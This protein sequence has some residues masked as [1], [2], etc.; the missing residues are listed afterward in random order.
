MRVAR[1]A[2]ALA[3]LTMAVAA[4]A[5]AA[6]GA[7]P[8]EIAPM[9]GGVPALSLAP[10]PTVVALVI[11]TSH[12]V[13]ALQRMV[14]RAQI[15]LREGD[16]LSRDAVRDAV[17]RLYATGAFSGVAVETAPRPGGVALIFVLPP[18]KRITSFT[19]Q[20]ASGV[21]RDVLTQAALAALDDRSRPGAAAHLPTPFF[22]SQL[23]RLRQ[24]L[25]AEY[26]TRGYPNAQVSA[27]AEDQNESEVAVVF[28]IDEGAP[29][30]LAGISASGDPRLSPSALRAALGLKLGEILDSSEV[31]AAV[32]RLRITYQRSHHY[33]A[34]V[35][36]PVAVPTGL[37]LGDAQ[38][39]LPVEA[40]PQIALRVHGNAH[41][42]VR[43]LMGVVAFTPDETLDE[44]EEERLAARLRAFYVLQGFFDVSVRP[45]EVWSPDRK[46]LAVFFDI[47]EGQPLRV[48]RIQFLGNAHFD[49]DFLVDRVHESLSEAVPANDAQV[50]TLQDGE[51]AL[52]AS[53]RPLRAPAYHAAPDT[54]FAEGPYKDA[55][56]R[57]VDLYRA[58]G[59]LQA[60]VDLP[61]LEID[62]RT[63]TAQVFVPVSEGPH[64]RVQSVRVSGV[65]D[66]QPLQALSSLAPG[67]SFNTAEEENTRLAMA[68]HLQKQGYLFARVT[69]AELFTP[70]HTGVQ[71]VY[72]VTTGPLVHV[73]SI[74]VRGNENTRESVI[75]A[76]LALRPGDLFD[77]AQVEQSEKNLSALGIFTRVEVHP[78]DPD[79]EDAQKDLVVEVDERPRTDIVASVGGSLIDGP[80]AYLEANRGNLLGLGLEALFQAKVNYFNL[81]YPVLVSK[82]LQAESGIDGF[83][84]HVDLGLRDPRIFLFQPAQVSAQ[85]DL[86][87][88]RIARPSYQFSREAA[89]LGF[90]WQITHWLRASLLNTV[91]RDVVSHQQNLADVI[92][93]LSQTD[94]QNLRFAEGT[95]V[96][97]SVTPTLT[98]DLRDSTANP[99]RGFLL[100][101][102][103]ELDHSLG[104]TS[105]A[106]TA[107]GNFVSDIK[108]QLTASVYLPL[109]RRTT[110]ALSA[111]M[112]RVFKLDP[113]SVT[114]APKR[115]FLGGTSTLRGYPEDG[116]VPEDTRA[117]LEG[118]VTA[119]NRQVVK[120]G[121]SQAA[122]ILQQGHILP[123]QGG[124]AFVLY[125]AEL[126]FPISG[127]FEGG[128]FIDA[129]NLWL[130]P[131]LLSFSPAKLRFTPGVGLR[132]ATPVGPLALDVGV[133]PFPDTELNETVLST[134][135]VQFSIGLF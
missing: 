116:L 78:L 19:F 12:R 9:T 109:G 72:Q 101:V 13:D 26:Q 86:V 10:A 32:K 41:F 74:I 54:V 110:L 80:R 14:L 28:S 134:S 103:A 49:N 21:G 127:N 30:R 128:L 48:T 37:G 94:L 7:D 133:N 99:H 75:R 27:R 68:R 3:L 15:G 35:G 92:N 4:P 50:A 90:D 76:G 33:R 115:F 51:A 125:K 47:D 123:S 97:G 85:V 1:F 122:D 88:E 89:N 17:D 131:S 55:I 43:T 65:V 71:V 52:P 5:A 64:T 67:A 11:Q 56:A 60:A 38:L 106:D 107:G 93:V 91:E 16:R 105:V 87:A 46:K 111:R 62:T 61:R 34:R 66:P 83:G 104:S 126:R 73:R 79:H 59:Y 82:Q 69:D 6:P 18:Q 42:G 44:S 36:Q 95:T 108:P 124:E 8:V 121:C 24:A 119:C 58:D 63:H 77:A 114:I 2:R 100:S 132:Y 39:L 113:N 112:G 45:E 40:G 118:Q 31:S 81:S 96:L 20:G 84:G 57:I 70:D 120:Q 23:E 117:D 98:V 29:M 53:D 129:G 135:Y 102:T 25:E 130:D 22:P